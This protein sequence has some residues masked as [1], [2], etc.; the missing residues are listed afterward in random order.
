MM[1]L[2]D[3]NTSK[4]LSARRDKVETLNVSNKSY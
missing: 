4:E 3:L 1:V 2:L